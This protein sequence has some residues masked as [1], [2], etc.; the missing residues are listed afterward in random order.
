MIIPINMCCFG[1]VPLAIGI[2]M[3]VAL[4]RADVKEGFAAV[5][6]ERNEY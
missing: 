3:I 6:S 5:E 4:G 2:W 1:L